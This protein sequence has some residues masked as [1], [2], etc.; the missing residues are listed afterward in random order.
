MTNAIVYDEG[1]K[2]IVS[3]RPGIDIFE[4]ADT[5]IADARG[6]AISY[7]EA[8]SALY[9]VNNDTIY[10]G[11]Q[12]S[13]LGGAGNGAITAGT[14]KCKFL[15]LDDKLILLDAANDQGWTITTGD[16]LAEIT[17]VDFP[18][19]QTP[20]VGI[21]HGGAVLNGYLYVLGENGVI[22]NSN[23]SDATAWTAIDFVEAERDPDG[24]IYLAKHHDHLAVFGSRTIEFFYDNG[25]PVGSPLNRR[26]D[27][28][29]NI[30]C[31]SGT[32]VWEMGDV[33]FFVGVNTVG[34]IGVYVI[35]NFAIRKISEGDFDAYLTQAIMKDGYEVLG[36]GNGAQ[37]KL[38]YILTMYLTPSDISPDISFAFDMTA[39][40][41]GEWE[42]I[43]GDQTKYPLVD[44]TIRTGDS[45][46]SGEGIMTNGD[47]ITINDNLTPLDTLLGDSYVA[48]GYVAS[49]Y[50]KTSSDSGDSITLKSRLGE[51][52][53]GTTNTKYMGPLRAVGDKTATAQNL[54]VKFSDNGAA[55]DSGRNLDLSA[56]QS[57]LNR[58]GSYERRN[59]EIEYSGTDHLRLEAI[60]VNVRSR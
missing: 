36:S 43:A 28:A 29:Y 39:G 1:G 19:K 21:T 24:G 17:D 13:E 50:Y 48:S 16:V 30:G 40:V 2:L 38:F 12:S 56:K 45:I 27:V 15:V 31:V 23:I 59:I 7:W 37:G 41:L 25:N 33:I 34:S 14:E 55:F 32:S 58:N 22:F 5:H 47:L 26:Q 49:G 35:E 44:W 6:R 4:E 54:T 46:R 20:A 9:I 52:D 11:S 10:K 57:Q 60:D 8:N 3:Q 53:N 51:T 42:T 18:P